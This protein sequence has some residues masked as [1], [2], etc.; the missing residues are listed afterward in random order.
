[1][2]RRGQAALE[3]LTTYGWAFLVILVMIGALAYFGVINPNTFLP[4]K[5]MLSQE[6]GC[7]DHQIT[8]VDPQTVNV[9]IFMI[10]SLGEAIELKTFNLT[11]PDSTTVTACTT[12]DI[13]DTNL[14]ETVGAGQSFTITCN[15]V[16][17]SFAKST[18]TKL[19]VNG[20]YKLTSGK[21]DRIFA[22]EIFAP[23][24]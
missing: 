20:K 15:N 6:F 9:K 12:I 8:Y 16:Q 2:M 7:K 11:S 3:F 18:K 13:G 1:M 10:N 19:L 17:G 14:P 23:V 5:C 4:E 24:Q 21:F 22:G